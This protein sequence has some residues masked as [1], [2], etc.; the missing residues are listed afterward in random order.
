M[1]VI[2]AK[3]YATWCHFCTELIPEWDKMKTIL[4]NSITV[5]EFES[6]EKE[7][8]SKFEAEHNTKIEVSGYPTIFKIRPGNP[9]EYFDN[10]IDKTA[11]NLKKWVLEKPKKKSS[12]RKRS[13]KK[14]KQNRRKTNKRISFM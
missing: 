8:L 2:I 1:T 14:Q 7:D 11:E 12:F 10:S 9:P 13:I 3:V 6:E 5:V 4:P